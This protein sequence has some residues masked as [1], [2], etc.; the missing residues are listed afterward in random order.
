MWG[1]LRSPDASLRSAFDLDFALPS[2]C[3]DRLASGEADIGIVPVIEMAR[4]KLEYF[5]GAGI[6]C[7]GPVRSILL[8]SMVP[9]LK[10]KTVAADS[11]SRTSVMLT[12]VIL[13]EKFGAEPQVYSQPPELAAM[14]GQADAALIIGDPALR[15]EPATLPFET[16]DLA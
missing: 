4:Q 14:L 11:G 1:F 7:H 16:L 15:L 9:F 2:V 13:A 12:R 8:I 3:S 6:A 10:V 5:R